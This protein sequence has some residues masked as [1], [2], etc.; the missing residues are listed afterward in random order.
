MI[1]AS[2]EDNPFLR[3]AIDALSGTPRLKSGACVSCSSVD[4]G[5]YLSRLREARTCWIESTRSSGSDSGSVQE[6][7]RE[8]VPVPCSITSGL[9]RQTG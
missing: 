5:P 9:N 3:S 4:V 1:N 8:Y 6:R 2:Y 7:T